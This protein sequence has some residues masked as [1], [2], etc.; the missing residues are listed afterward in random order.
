[1]VITKGSGRVAEVAARFTLDAMPGKQMAI[2]ADLNAGII[3]EDEARKRRE[4]MRAEWNGRINRYQDF[5]QS[6]LYYIKEE[7]AQ[8]FYDFMTCGPDDEVRIFL[9]EF[10]MGVR[11]SVLHNTLGLEPLYAVSHVSQLSDKDLLYWPH[12]HVLWGIR[13]K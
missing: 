12:I 1:M 11:A 7:L 8:N 3:N 6:Q 10:M 13:N 2:D 4:E 5:F 9:K